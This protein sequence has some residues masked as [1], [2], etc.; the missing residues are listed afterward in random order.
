MDKLIE[1]I[2]IKKNYIKETIQALHEV[3]HQSERTIIELSAIG[4][5]L[6]HTYNGI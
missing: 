3:L 2:L 6:H 5:F 1:E 4:S